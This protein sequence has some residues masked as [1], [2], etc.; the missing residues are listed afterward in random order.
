MVATAIDSYPF[1]VFELA[2]T[3]RFLSGIFEPHREGAFR[4]EK[5]L[6]NLGVCFPQLAHA[7]YGAAHF[8]FE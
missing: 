2:R 4:D 8:S 5:F 3:I 7:Q 1:Q 6:S